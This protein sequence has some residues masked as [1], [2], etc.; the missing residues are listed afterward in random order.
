MSDTTTAATTLRPYVAD[1]SPPDGMRALEA[2]AGT[3]KTYSITSTVLRLVAEEGLPME[4]LLVVTFTRAATAE[5]VERTRQRLQEGA[6]ALARAMTEPDWSPSDEVLAHVIAHGRGGAGLDATLRRVEQ[7]LQQV[8]E[9]MIS[10]IHGF[11]QRVLQQTPFASLVDPGLELEHDQDR[12]VRQVVDD[13]AVALLRDAPDELHV[14]LQEVGLAPARLRAVGTAI[15]NEPRPHVVPALDPRPPA[16]IVLPAVERLRVAIDAGRDDLFAAAQLVQDGG[17]VSGKRGGKGG[18]WA[19]AKV[20]AAVDAARDA[21]RGGDLPDGRV[22]ALLHPTGK[23]DSKG[24]T[25]PQEM[26]DTAIPLAVGAHEQALVELE[27]AVRTQLAAHVEHE[28]RRRREQ[29]GTA[30]FA[31]LLRRLDEA[32]DRDDGRLTA[33]LR[34]T[35]RA[36]LVDEFQDTDPVQW[37]ILHRVFGDGRRLDVVGDPKQA[38]YGWRGADLQTYVDAVGEAGDERWTMVTNHRSDGA[39]VDACNRALAGGGTFGRDDVTYVHVD[40]PHAR[41]ASR[42]WSAD[43][44]PLAGID[45]VLHRRAD[46]GPV[47]VGPAGVRCARR[48]AEEIVATLADAPLLRTHTRDGELVSVRPVGPGDC[49]VLVRT[50]SQGELVADELRRRGVPVVVGGGRDVLTSPEAG[51]LDHLLAALLA[52]AD[53]RAL[54]RVLAGPVGG[55]DAPALAALDDAAWGRWFEHVSDW[56]GRWRRQGVSAAVEAA[57]RDGGAEVRLAGVRGGERVLTNLR[58]L[59]ELLHRTE[60]DEALGAEAL[61]AWLAARRAE[62]ADG[63]M[64]PEDREQRLERDSDAVRVLTVHTAKGLEFPLVWLPFAWG[65]DVRRDTHEERHRPFTVNDPEQGGRRTVVLHPSGTDLA[66]ASAERT[67]LR[68]LKDRDDWESGH[69]LLYVA[70][71]RAVHRCTVHLVV[72]ADVAASSLWHVLFRGE[73]GEGGPAGE[74]DVPADDVLLGVLEELHRQEPAI[75]VTVAQE[76]RTVTRWSSTGPAGVEPLD[77]RTWRRTHPLDVTWGR[78]SYSRL[79]SQPGAAGPVEATPQDARDTAE[80]PP[81]RAVHDLAPEDRGAVVPLQDLPRGRSWGTFVHDVLEHAAFDADVAGLARSV[82]ERRDAGVLP[83]TEPQVDLLARGLH[84]ALATPLGPALD[85]LRLRDVPRRDRLDELGFAL[86]LA[87]RDRPATLAALAD[88]FTAHDPQAHGVP[89]AQA[90][91]RLRD[92]RGDDPVHGLLVGFVD[93]VLRHPADGRIWIVD[94]KTNGLGER[95]TDADGA[96]HYVEHAGHQH[97]DRVMSSM[98]EHDYLVQAHLYVVA[99]HRWLRSRLGDG[100]DYDEHIGGWAYL[101]LRGMTGEGSAVAADGRPHGLASARP[102]RALVEDLDAVLD[103]TGTGERR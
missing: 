20:E 94:Y 69:R 101:Y 29:A 14:A 15:A 68:A 75:R 92:G 30:S 41:P 54:R 19:L 70:L 51:E 64:P 77:V 44:V 62:A 87:A 2:S 25:M 72:T 39:Y 37:S 9:A 23:T 11:C 95:T 81:G 46:D 43:G 26:A 24:R 10:T 48:T 17:S 56:S 97:P 3:G 100:Y 16:A 91:D 22:T 33:E 55:L 61:A 42:L 99:V 31:D 32:L 102:S 86:G 59:G 53:E 6:R 76:D 28:V 67:R 50:K 7:A 60:R 27:R 57:L 65:S 66:V 79:V 36:V 73:L 74:V 88:V 38:I 85:G 80:P 1:G 45:V 71:T 89:L 5:L 35:H 78:A 58:H 21:L 8:D 47:P 12:L 96:Q 90:A 40:T 4:A 49:A 18:I 82:A 63:A 83:V 103:G 84:A 13:W 52:P 98:L 34:A 93:L